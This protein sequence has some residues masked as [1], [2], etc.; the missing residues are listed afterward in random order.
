MYE[1][2]RIIVPSKRPIL[3]RPLAIDPIESIEPILFYLMRLA[4]LA[5]ALHAA[6]RAREN[7]AYGLKVPT[8]SLVSPPHPG[9]AHC[10]SVNRARES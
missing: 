5:P 9:M 8:E 6:S 4:T 2:A 7:Q 1:S 10:S 3:L